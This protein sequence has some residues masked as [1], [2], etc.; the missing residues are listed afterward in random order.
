[1]ENLVAGT[2]N[3]AVIGAGWAGLACALALAE[4]GV[5]VCV[6]ESAR[7]A[8]GRAR[9]VTHAGTDLDNGQHMLV[10]AYRETL[11][12]IQRFDPGLRGLSRL[13]LRIEYPHRFRLAAPRLPAP[14]HL[15]AGLLGARGMTVRERLS[16]LRFARGLKHPHVDPHTH[17]SRLIEAQP[18]TAR[19]YLWEPLCLAALNT[20]PEQASA[21]VFL[22]VLRDSF[23]RSRSD[24]DLLLPRTDLTALFPEPA[25]ARVAERGGSFRRACRVMDFA[26]SG[27]GFELHHARG[28][29]PCSHLVIATSPPHA[30]RLL[31]PHPALASLSRMLQDFAY[32]AIVT[33]N[34]RY[35]AA[36][37]MPFPILGLADGPGQWVFDRGA[38]HEQTGWLSVVTSCPREAIRAT[39]ITTQLTRELH[40]TDPSHHFTVNEKRATWRCTPGIARPANR[41]PVRNLYLAGDYT[42][43]PYPAT[44]EGA[45]RSGLA[46]AQAIIGA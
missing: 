30:S 21:Q 8:G 10:G 38:T 13:P 25:L 32:E 28:S 20:R 7:E 43:G 46:C 39:D 6:F 1:M 18:R 22:N 5:R 3:V 19:R 15:L 14:W 17:V 42:D 34:L 27:H 36:P 16:C 11:A 4:A 45:V 44:L 12:L 31:E 33:T 24:S 29:E 2:V 37:R 40:L 23:A 9:R 26:I 35:A 41:T